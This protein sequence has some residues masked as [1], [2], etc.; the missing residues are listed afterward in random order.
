MYVNNK[1]EILETALV[2]KLKELISEYMLVNSEASNLISSTIETVTDLDLLTDI[3]VTY[4]PMDQN[5]K[6]LYMNEFDYVKRAEKLINDINIELEVLNLDTKIDDEIREK[7]EKE[8]RDFILKEK[9][10]K[11]NNELGILTDKQLEVNNY[12]EL[13]KELSLTY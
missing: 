5:K 12:K 10:N 4:L 11:L 8:Q 13:L 6:L 3:I 2:R 1:D 9:I 7:F